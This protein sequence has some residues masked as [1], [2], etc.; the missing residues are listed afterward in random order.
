[1]KHRVYLIRPSKSSFPLLRDGEKSSVY[2]S[3]QKCEI[4]FCHH[5]N[6]DIENIINLL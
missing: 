5:Q 1:M 2:F 3:R 4:T 6:P